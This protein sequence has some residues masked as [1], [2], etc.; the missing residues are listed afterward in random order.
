[1]NQARIA[2]TSRYYGHDGLNWN[3]ITSELDGI[4]F[5]AGVGMLQDYAL[6][7]S[8]DEALR[9]EFPYATYH[10]PVTAAKAGCTVEVQAQ[11][12]LS[13]P[14]VADAL[15]IADFEPSSRSDPRMVSPAEALAYLRVI[16]A[17]S[18]WYSN[19][20]YSDQLGNPNFLLAYPLLAAQYPYAPGGEM[21]Y[22]S[23]D[24]FLAR[25]AGRQ[26]PWVAAS[27]YKVNCVGWQFT[28]HGK[29]PHIGKINTGGGV[30]TDHDFSVSTIEK[31]VFMAKFWKGGGTVQPPPGESE[32]TFIVQTNNL[33]VRP[34]PKADDNLYP[35]TRRLPAGALWVAVDIFAPASGGEAW[36]QNQAGEWACIAKGG[37]QHMRTA[38]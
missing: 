17:D 21:E 6:A 33:A 25:W 1:M 38:G 14:G 36:A 37:S 26:A 20:K 5:C 8:V 11:R 35:A 30:K 16:G 7:E 10:I 27:K 12:Y 13:W 34:A 3:R 24:S 29:T 15:R 28:A 32:M 22:A 23:F 19:K 9:R 4:I 2:D 18:W 31:D